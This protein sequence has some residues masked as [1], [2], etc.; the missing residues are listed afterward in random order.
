LRKI[1]KDIRRSIGNLSESAERVRTCI[2][3]R[4]GVREVQKYARAPAPRKSCRRSGPRVEELMEMHSPFLGDI[5]RLLTGVFF[6]EALRS[7]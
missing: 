4:V 7:F 1:E 5:R 3:K 6:M 2:G